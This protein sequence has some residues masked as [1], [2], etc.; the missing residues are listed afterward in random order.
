MVM[1]P[2]IHV[3][4]V[5][6]I[7]IGGLAVLIICVSVTLTQRDHTFS[8]TSSNVNGRV[9]ICDLPNN[10]IVFHTIVQGLFEEGLIPKGDVL[11]IG[12]NTGEWS[13]AFACLYEDRI[14]HAADPSPLLKTTLPCPKQRN[15]RVHA[16]AMSDAVGKISFHPEKSGAY[17]GSLERKG[18]TDSDAN[19]DV[20]TLDLFFTKERSGPGFMHLDVEG[21][22]RKLII[23]GRKTIAQYRPVFSFEVHM[24]TE[25]SRATIAAV[26]DLGYAVFMVNEACGNGYCRNNLALPVNSSI[27]YTQSTTLRLAMRAGVLFRVTSSTADSVYNANLD[28]AKPRERFANE[29]KYGK[30]HD[31]FI[32][33]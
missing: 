29:R 32:P 24:R 6:G 12:A 26:E 18:G 8:A 23:G 7:V 4:N 17:V 13:C 3:A 16:L 25:E 5:R 19:V 21:Y 2:S 31:A 9:A 1:S 28:N 20:T 15:V 10:E 11:D 33:R 14:V 27:Q 22:E 30:A